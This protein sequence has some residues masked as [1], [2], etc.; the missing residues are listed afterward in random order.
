MATK[1]RSNRENRNL[2]AESTAEICERANRH[3]QEECVGWETNGLS[4]SLGDTGREPRNP[5][6]RGGNKRDGDQVVQGEGGE[7][8]ELAMGART[9]RMQERV[10]KTLAEAME[11]PH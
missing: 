8:G 10:V 1:F 4:Q 7:W 5:G 11:R 9:E 6:S 3:I 2:I